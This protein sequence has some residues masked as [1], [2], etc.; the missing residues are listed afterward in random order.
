MN[1]M[2]VCILTYDRDD[3]ITEFLKTQ[4]ELYEQ[5][6]VD[7]WIYD[8]NENHV[9][10]KT[11]KEYIKLYSNL[12]YVEVNSNLHSNKK[13]LQIIKGYGRTKKYDY[14]WFTQDAFRIEQDELESIIEIVQNDFDIITI[15]NDDSKCLSS[16]EYYDVREYFKDSA[17]KLTGYGNCILKT[18]SMIDNADWD[19]IEKKYLVDTCINYAHV[20]YYFEQLLLI[21]QPK[22]FYKH[23]NYGKYYMS[24][25]KKQPSWIENVFHIICEVWVGLIDKL[26]DYYDVYKK[27]VIK[28]LC[29]DA[30]FFSFRKFIYYRKLD[31]YNMDIYNKYKNIWPMLCDLD[32]DFLKKLAET[33][34]NE[35]ENFE[36]YRILKFY[37][38]Y[39]NIYIYGSGIVAN[40]VVEILKRNKKDW[41][42]FLVSDVSLNKQNLHNHNIVK[43]EKKMIKK[44]VGIIMGVNYKNYNEIVK[45]YNLYT[46][47]NHL[48]AMY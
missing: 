17:W 1:K 8:S 27:E 4:V 10:G 38:K 6:E 40:E 2:A 12:Y 7:V 26:P 3:L 46:L 43:F 22:M 45:K 19:K 35:V 39:R 23:V 29:I 31:I 5:F 48:L 14:I 36:N 13:A 11:I 42:S 44:D 32:E 41:I 16:K 15:A 21:E 30:N 34:L 25:L 9:C 47:E 28:S 18:S 24:K 33:E 20:G 37:E